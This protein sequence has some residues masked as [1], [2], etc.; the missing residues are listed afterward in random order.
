MNRDTQVGLA[1]AILLIG[2]VGAMFLRNQTTDKPKPVQDSRS[3]PERPP[4]SIDSPRRAETD[5][6]PPRVSLASPLPS[7]AATVHP[8]EPKPESE[9]KPEP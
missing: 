2:V 9:P 8:G 3:L 5:A 6:G 7:A 1:L 4:A